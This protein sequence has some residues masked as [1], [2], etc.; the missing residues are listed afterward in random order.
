MENLLLNRYEIVKSLSSGGFGDTFLAKDTQVPS[1][2][3]VVVK[4]L[5]PANAGSNTST[6]LIEKLFEKEA[7]VLEDLGEHN[8]QIPKLYSYFSD[9]NEFYLVQEYIQGVSLSD[10]APIGQEQAKMI[11]SSLLATLKY[12]H[13][14]GIIHRDI[15]PENIILR[16]SDRL[17]VLI[18]FGAVKETMGM[19]TLGSGSTVS[20]VVIGTRGFMAPEQSAGRSVFSTD[21]YA[22]GLTVIYAMTK[23]LPVEFATSQL[24]G[25]LDWQSEIP[26][27]NQELAKVLDKSIKMEPSRRYPTAEAMYQ[28]LHSLLSSGAQPTPT[29]ETIKVAPSGGYSTPSNS[30]NNAPT[31]VAP[32]VGNPSQS[33]D[34][35]RQKSGAATALT[36][37]LGIIF[38]AGGLGGG[39]FVT[40][41]IKQAEERAAQAERDKEEAERKRIEAEQKIAAEAERR[42]AE[43]ERQRELEAQKLEEERKRLAAEAA[44]ARKERERLA[45][46]RRRAQELANR[47][48]SSFDNTSSGSMGWQSSCGDPYASGYSWW[49]VKGPASALGTV[50]NNYCG[51]ALIVKGETQVASF[52]SES[53]AWSFANSL[54]G[55][56][57]YS[58]WVKKSR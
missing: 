15:K 38:V 48:Q 54:S 14:K 40:Q 21:L 2:K 58:F 44:Q 53:A 5:K 22:L 50:K 6:E 16:D 52:R 19:V 36:I 39:F 29:M 31:V 47:V 25:E 20:S 56:S 24:T 35:G 30:S 51:D 34:Q 8:S 45:A 32:P 3:L 33:Y 7:S 41:Q 27:I 49:A 17:P 23:K 43:A 28:D 37:L 42:A 26:N 1:Q 9:N 13:G 4:R 57:G 46:E 12:I 18:D 11:L 10:A 55:V